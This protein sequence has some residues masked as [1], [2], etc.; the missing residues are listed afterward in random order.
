MD[1]EHIQEAE[2]ADQATGCSGSPE[3]QLYSNGGD[4]VTDE[5]AAELFAAGNLIEAPNAGAGSYREVL[6]RLGV[7]VS[8]VLDW[9][10]SAGDW[11]FATPAGVVYQH[12]RYPY[13]GFSYGLDPSAIWKF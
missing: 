4:R 11:V 7:E 10:S 3:G 2:T 5:E 9:T 12:N 6:A 8:E 13:H 1:I